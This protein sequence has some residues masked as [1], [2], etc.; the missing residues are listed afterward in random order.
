MLPNH[1]AARVQSRG[2]GV[3]LQRAMP[4]H[5]MLLYRSAGRLRKTGKF[6]RL[7]PLL[8]RIAFVVQHDVCGDQCVLF[9]RLGNRLLVV[10]RGGLMRC[11]SAWPALVCRTTVATTCHGAVAEEGEAS[12]TDKCCYGATL[13]IHCRAMPVS[14]QP[15]GA[16]RNPNQSP[17]HNPLRR[18]NWTQTRSRRLK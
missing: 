9:A 18:E 12:A 8:V 15:P 4:L 16:A 7:G 17:C 10:L 11:A 1:A 13:P 14:R 6:A 2:C 3:L 5:P